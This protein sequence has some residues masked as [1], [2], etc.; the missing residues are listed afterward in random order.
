M[1]NIG[2]CPPL[3]DV[4]HEL[5]SPSTADFL[6]FPAHVWLLMSTLMPNTSMTQPKQELISGIVVTSLCCICIIDLFIYVSAADLVI[7]VPEFCTVFV[8]VIP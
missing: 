7:D 4:E 5:M 8:Y 3:V 2:Q 6:S 1:R